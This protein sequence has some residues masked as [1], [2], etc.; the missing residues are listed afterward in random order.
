[1][2]IKG[3]TFG[4]IGWDQ[5]VKGDE[6]QNKNSL[7]SRLLLTICGFKLLPTMLEPFGSRVV[8]NAS[9]ATEENKKRAQSVLELHNCLPK[10]WEE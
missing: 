2:E 4:K 6:D 3:D 7:S 10:S 5:T 1:M 8:K 9:W